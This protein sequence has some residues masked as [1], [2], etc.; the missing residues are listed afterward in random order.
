MVSLVAWLDG[1]EAS[2]HDRAGEA[3]LHGCV[4]EIRSLRR[5]MALPRSVAGV[6]RLLG[7][8]QVTALHGYLAEISCW[9][10]TVAWPRSGHC[11][12]RLLGRDPKAARAWVF[13][14][15]FLLSSAFWCL[16]CPL[17]EAPPA[18]PQRL[19]MMADRDDGTSAAMRRRQRRLGSWWRH[20]QRSVAAALETRPT[21]LF[22]TVLPQNTLVPSQQ[23][24]AFFS[25]A[26]P[27]SVFF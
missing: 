12:A 26:E 3:E 1:H 6:A 9:R 11:V 13:E 20:E 7:R 23:S 16:F 5:T 17:A 15:L 24:L 19:V 14:C 8:D 25:A 10:C 2:P 4:S 27:A 22:L 18:R 21:R